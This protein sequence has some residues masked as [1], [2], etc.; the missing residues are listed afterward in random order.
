M[1]TTGNTILITGGSSGI[2]LALA[3]RLSALGNEVIICGRTQHKL[4]GAKAAIPAIH[5]FRCDISKPEDCKS[6]YEFVIANFNGINVL[7]NNAGV[8]RRIDL[9]SGIDAVSADDEFDI[10][11]KPQVHLS[12]M[13]I[14]ILRK[15]NSAIIN[16]SSG[17]G[18][19]PLSAF[20]V[21]CATKAAIHS[22]T[23]SL[24]RQLKE[25]TIRVFAVIPP[26]VHDTGLKGSPIE[27]TDYSVSASEVAD[28]VVDGMENDTF[29]IA[30]GPAK[31]WVSASKHE[32]D[33]AFEQINK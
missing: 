15:C 5:T 2:G 24:R 29:E 28:A 32:L 8:Q 7:V 21:Y 26:T 23:M 17:L 16:V 25:T 3:K 10:N 4:D 13:F 1:K 11:F 14:P 12:V 9:K 19:V 33:Q 18:F 20:P 6:L 30:I 22:F 31:R 27:K